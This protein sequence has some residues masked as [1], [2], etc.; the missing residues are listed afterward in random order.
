MDTTLYL[1]SV[2]S[3]VVSYP[4]HKTLVDL[5]VEQAHRTPH[6]VAVV[7]ENEQ[8]TYQELD[9][10]SNQLAHYLRKLGV[11]EESLVPICLTRSINMIVGILGILKAGGA[12]VP[13]DPDYPADRIIYM[14]ADLKATIAV[15][16]VASRPMLERMVEGVNLVCLDRDQ[17]GIRNEVTTFVATQLTPKSLAYIIYTSGSTGRPKGVMIDHE[18]VVRLFV[19]DA[20]LFDFG[21][22]DVWTMFHS[23]CFDFSVWEMYGALLFGGRLVVVPKNVAKDATLFA[24]LLATEKV[25]VLNQT[26]SAFYV[27]QEQAVSKYQT[28]AVRYVIFGGEALNPSKLRSW[29]QAYPDCALINMY[30]ITETTVHVTY[31]AL[32]DEHLSQPSS[33]IGRPIPTLSTYILDAE[34]QPVTVGEVGELYVGGAGLARGYLN[35]PELTAKRF[36]P[37]PFSNHAGDRLYRSGDLARLLPGG[38]LE[39]MG[40][41]DEQVKIRGFRIEL[42]EI[43]QVMLLCPGIKHTV[44]VAKS[45]GDDDVRLVAYVVLDG[46]FDKKTIT[47]FLATRLP[48]YM[49]P[50]LLVPIEHIP[51]TSNGKVDR[52][53]LPTPDASTSLTTSYAAPGNPT[54]E[55]LIQVWKDVLAVSRVGVNDNFFELGGNSLLAVRTVT[56]LKQLHTYD[57]PVTKLYQFPTIHALA[58]YL[59]GGHQ[60]KPRS[61]GRTTKK[62]ESDDV[63]IIGMAGRFPGADSVEDLWDVLKT[64]RETIHFFTD[65]ELDSSLSTDL[66]GDPAYVKARGILEKAAQFDAGFFGL[67]AKLAEVMDPQHRVFMEIAWEVLEQT[68]YLPNQYGERIG[69]WAGCGNNTYYLNNVLANKEVLNQIGSFQ[70]MTVNEKDFIASRTAYQLNL[71]GPA[72]SVYSACSTSLLA[73]AQAVDSIRLGH[74]ELA[75]AGGAS[76][77]AP[78]YSGHLYE[79]GAMLSRD[80]HCRP[81]DAQATGTVFSDGAG[82]VLLKSREAAERDGDTI[83]AIIKGVGVNNDGG[84]KGSFTAPNA[85]GQAIAIRTALEDARIDPS[86]ISYVEAHGTATPLGDPIEI[87]GLMMAFGDVDQRQFCALG[88]IKSNLGHLTAAAGVAGLIKTTLA[89]RYKELPA[90]LGF[91]TPNPVIPFADSPFYVND[92]HREWTTTGPRRAGISSFGVGG[93]N[94]HVVVEEYAPL[95]PVSQPKTPAKQRHFQLFPWSAKSEQSLNNHALNLANYLREQPDLNVAD[96]VATLQ[97]RQLTHNYRRYVLARTQDELIATL[98]AP[99]IP[100]SVTSA[101]AT[102]NEIVFLFP[103]QGA[104][105]VNMG[106]ELYE[107]EPVY[108]QAVDTCAEG[109]LPHLEADI[110]DVLFPETVDQ[111]AVERL[112]DTRYTQPALFTTNYALAR[113]WQSWGVEPTVFCGHSIGEFVAAHLAGVFSL[114]DALSLIAARGQLISELPSGGMLS[115]RLGAD[116][117]TAMLPDTL[118]L[119]AVNS[120]QLCVVAGPN[121]AIATF[122]G[123]LEKQNIP[124]RLLETSHAFHSS[125]L[126][127]ILDEFEKTVRGITLRRPQKPIVSTVTGTWLTDSDA[128]N[129]GYWTTHM[130]ATVRFADALETLFTLENP[131]LLET[132]P[133]NVTATLARQQATPRKVN[134]VASLDGTKNGQTDYESV[135]KALGQLWIKGVNPDWQAFRASHP[136]RIITLP[137]YAFDRKHCWVDPPK[138]TSSISID[139]PPATVSSLPTQHVIAQ[140]IMRKNNIQIAVKT[141]LHEITGVDAGDVVPTTSFLELG[142]D[143]LIL[144]QFSYT[145]RKKFGLPISFRQLNNE[146]GTLETLV[147][148]LDQGL[149]ADAYQPETPVSSP[150]VSPPPAPNPVIAT[151]VP[152]MPPVVRP[153]SEGLGTTDSIMTLFEQQLQIMAQQMAVLRGQEV[154]AMPAPTSSPVTAEALRSTSVPTATGS[155]K[156]PVKPTGAIQAF[157]AGAR[158]ERQASALNKTQEAFLQQ[159]IQRYV[160]KTSAS[161]TNT[162]ENRQWLADPRAVTGFK[163]LTKELVYPLVVDKSKGS[164]LWDIDGNEYIDALNGFGSTL[165]GHQPEWLTRVLHEQI[166]QGYEL[167]PQH[168][169]AGEVA[170]LICEFTSFDRAALCNTGSEAI[171]GTIRMART[172]TGRSLIVTF[173][174]SYHGIFDEVVSRGSHDRNATPAA[175]GIM[176]EAVQNVLVLDYGT[177]ESLDTI[178]TRASEIAAVLVEPIQSRRPEFQPVEFLRELRS[179]TSAAGTALIFDEVITGFRMH[180]GGMQGFWGIQ[181]DLAAY[182]KVVGGGMPIGVMAGKSRFMDALDGGFW[183]YGDTSF[184]QADITFFAGTFARHPLALAASHASLRYMREQGP[185]LQER[186]TAK[187]KRLADTLNT[188]LT[189][190]QLPI[191][192]AQFGSLWK[193]KF[194]QDVPYGELVFTLMRE[195]GIHIWDGFPCFM[196]EAHT[197]ADIKRIAEAFQESIRALIDAQF[198]SSPAPV[199][200]KAAPKPTNMVNSVDHPPVAGAKLGRDAQGNV[201]WFFKDPSRPGKYL[202]LVIN[203]PESLVNSGSANGSSNGTH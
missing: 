190:R 97:N 54:E 150:V 129:P 5:L 202:Q 149:P 112:K 147:D 140:P 180:P 9:A 13:I 145:L 21:E 53:A 99:A 156:A 76:V 181:A 141:L 86:T 159:L 173:A 121:E 25:T 196:T 110:R 106:L 107:N 49:V 115:V 45:Y 154:G 98:T 134:V 20:P 117:V 64:G 113:L 2:A 11:A 125:M 184:P 17:Q 166:E 139:L 185:A 18:N 162:Q 32:T 133:G 23:F 66:T 177:P 111:E 175:L 198:L 108:R 96:V 165:F 152:L 30:G 203:K 172:V 143:S 153:V 92:T 42:G 43:E 182:G 128:T 151:S 132:G 56:L 174:G 34:Q 14:L 36:I 191:L 127:P 71:G 68:G 100:H 146:F 63:A 101:A 60:T 62:L 69:V 41:I 187:A 77:T 201:A 168:K 7:F 33:L 119:A 176:P 89:L 88:S 160:R 94:V 82:V 90:S 4:K 67:S 81:F 12:Y 135:M 39:Y 167:G 148:Y 131:M 10:Q 158:I 142:L 126:D 137:T 31:L 136:Q 193:I 124:N 120:R 123:E 59:D 57:T 118:S 40:R 195:R 83:Y 103:G 161:K 85:E 104:Q 178:Q 163:P 75:L 47:D 95:E 122:A 48:D 179:I 199:L 3:E 52:K 87:E 22:Q 78:I 93:T 46:T 188:F 130:R 37:N 155:I 197:D 15:T 61:T 19:N 65:A 80:G 183:Q 74:C 8:L 144:T 29:K 72:V 28:L 189:Q 35:Q 51:L 164:R 50:R 1:S 102:P 73:V 27:L 58:N 171:M 116:Q 186:L 44:V 105:Y 26:P 194:T 70:A 157:G 200:P 169:L 170:R 114:P 6:N 91:D 192:I 38:D 138:P 84:G 109:L 16:D 24:T 79:E 55:K